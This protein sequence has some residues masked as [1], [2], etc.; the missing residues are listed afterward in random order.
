M[1]FSFTELYEHAATIQ[2]PSQAK[3]IQT[4]IRSAVNNLWG[5][6]LIERV[7]LGRYR[8]VVNGLLDLQVQQEKA[9]QEMNKVP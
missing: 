8:I 3:D 1:E 2:I 5:Y 9:Y 6:K 7:G 4:A